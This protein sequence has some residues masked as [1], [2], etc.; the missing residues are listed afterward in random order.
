MSAAT[1]AHNDNQDKRY[2][3]SLQLGLWVPFSFPELSSYSDERRNFEATS[4]SDGGS[5]D[6]TDTI[7]EEDKTW[8]QLVDP[9]EAEKAIIVSSFILSR[10]YC[11]A[12]R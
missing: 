7:A 2:G 11:W 4:S 3:S 5:C 1:I 12:K 10:R 9:K 8:G 6:S